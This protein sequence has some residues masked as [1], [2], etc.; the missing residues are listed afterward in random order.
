[1]PYLCRRCQKQFCSKH[2][3]PES[4]DCTGI[5][6]K[7]DLETNPVLRSN[8][9][10]HR[11]PGSPATVKRR[12]DNGGVEYHTEYSYSDEAPFQTR[13]KSSGGRTRF[14]RTEVFHLLI[15]SALLLLLSLSEFFPSFPL[16]SPS[17]FD[18]GDFVFLTLLLF[19]GFL[20]HE[21][22]HKAVAQ[23]YGLFAEFRI[24]PSYAFLT[25]LLILLPA[26]KLFA[27]GAV[28]IGGAASPQ[29]YGKTA[30][31]GPATNL[32]VGGV[33]LGLAFLLPGYASSFLFGAF[34]SGWLAFFNMLPISPL[35]GGKV[36]H[37]SRGSFAAL[38][39]TSLV[40]FI[41]P[42]FLLLT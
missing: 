33:F 29:E 6:E 28:M 31:A 36:L 20:L 32:V 21:L 18:F 9:S 38:F 26:F 17:S 7:Q 19:L 42:L 34:F 23:R 39:S 11:L 1:M 15:A 40:L 16:L 27:P 25:L 30:A 41:V 4:H 12:D 5:R 10:S 35:D 14:S 24:V 2:R 8:T 22:M 3:L 13:H 37:W